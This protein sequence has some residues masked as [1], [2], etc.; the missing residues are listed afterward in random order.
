MTRVEEP[1][2]EDQREDADAADRLLRSTGAPV[3]ER[4]E[5]PFL[6]SFYRSAVVKKWLMAL[7]GIV[8]LVYGF[9]TVQRRTHLAHES[10][11]DVGVVRLSRF[12]DCGNGGRRSGR[13]RPHRRPAIQPTDGLG[14]ANR[15]RGR[16]CGHWVA[17]RSRSILGADE[18]DS[19]SDTRRGRRA[20]SCTLA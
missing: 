16:V 13:L 14:P 17:V 18:L 12:D 15:A 11:V 7:S 1:S 19:P 5:P 6:L 10:L 9:L 4:R 3:P 20:R 8:L 2:T